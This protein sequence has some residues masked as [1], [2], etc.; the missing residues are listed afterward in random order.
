[1]TTFN[2]TEHA[3]VPDDFAY[4]LNMAGIR[5]RDRLQQRHDWTPPKRIGNAVHIFD[6]L[7]HE[8]G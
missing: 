4:F 6:T 2:S 7:V 5:A 3:G 8:E 1:M